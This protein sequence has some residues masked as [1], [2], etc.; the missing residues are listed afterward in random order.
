M[1]L[2]M[3]KQDTSLYLYLISVQAMLGPK[4]GLDRNTEKRS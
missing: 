2:T 1:I 3:E 4:Q